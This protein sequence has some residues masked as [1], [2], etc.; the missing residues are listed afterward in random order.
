MSSGLSKWSKQVPSGKSGG[1]A[2]KAVTANQLAVSGT[3]KDWIRRSNA[4][5]R[6]DNP[7]NW[8]KDED[9]WERAKAAVKPHWDKYDEPYAVVTHVYEN[10]GGRTK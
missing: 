7:A 10:M 3:I 6:P 8:V 5:D 2:P 1:G 4:V 9:V